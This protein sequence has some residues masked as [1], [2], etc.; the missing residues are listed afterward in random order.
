MT[1][2]VFLQ[3]FH[4]CV[5]MF[6]FRYLIRLFSCF[7]S[8]YVCSYW[9]FEIVCRCCLGD[10]MVYPLQM[11]RTR[12]TG[13][14]DQTPTPPARAA[15]DRGCGRDRGRARGTAKTPARAATEEP[16]VALFGGQTPEAP[17]ATLALQKTLAQFLSLFGTLAQAG[18]IPL[19]PATFRA[20]GG[21]QTPSVRTPEQWVQVDQ[22]PE[23][24]P[25][26]PV[27]PVQPVVRATTSEEKQLRLERFKKYHPYFQYF[28]FRG[29]TWFS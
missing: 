5:P 9:S 14:D 22:V 29:C 12:T 18:L 4:L 11:V 17:I 23:V 26:Q 2:W 19:A 28:G 24:I 8:R 3:L 20:G 6:R 1:T 13:S 7:V 25:V 21:A 27:A 15:R 10:F 16:P